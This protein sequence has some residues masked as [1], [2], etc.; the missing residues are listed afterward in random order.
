MGGSILGRHGLNLIKVR[1]KNTSVVFSVPQYTCN[2]SHFERKKSQ[3]RGE[4]RKWP[5]DQGA[6]KKRE[7]QKPHSGFLWR[8][9]NEAKTKSGKKRKREM[10]FPFQ[11]GHREHV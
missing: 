8:E 2:V 1:E 5:E 4:R 10:I 6:K 11:W 3:K 9:K 7:T